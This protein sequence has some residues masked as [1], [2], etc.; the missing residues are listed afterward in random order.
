[1]ALTDGLVSRYKLD[2]NSNDSVGSNNWTDFNL[3]SYSNVWKIWNCVTYN[4]SIQY[5]QTPLITNATTNISISAWVYISW[6]SLAG[7]FVHNGNISWTPDD[8][9]SIWVGW[10]TFDN[11]GNN[12]IALCNGVAW[13]N[14]NK[15]IWTWRHHVAITRDWTTRRWYVD[16]VVSATTFTSNP[17]IPTV[18]TIF[19][20]NTTASWNMHFFNGREDLIWVWNKTLT[21]TEIQSLYNSWNW[22]DYP[23]TTNNWAGFL[24]MM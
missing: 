19:G 23:F 18:S 16:S 24:M 2:S 5:T 7:C 14:F 6:T 3:P 4:W 21:L 22:L 9:Y 20:R 13:M 8:W 17:N 12:L 1:M 10:T 15:V 11:T